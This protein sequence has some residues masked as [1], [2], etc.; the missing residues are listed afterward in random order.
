MPISVREKDKKIEYVPI[1]IPK[2]MV[3]LID[4]IIQEKKF[5]YVSR[6]DFVRDAIRRRLDEILRL[7]EEQK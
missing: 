7:Y 2:E 6:N 5:A 4:K 3:E 1:G